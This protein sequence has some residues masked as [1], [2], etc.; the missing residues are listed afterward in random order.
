MAGLSLHTRYKGVHWIM[1]A[2]SSSLAD[3]LVSVRSAMSKFSN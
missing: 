1:D 2:S 3:R